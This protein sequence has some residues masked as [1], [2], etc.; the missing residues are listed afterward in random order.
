MS[1][2]VRLYSVEDVHHEEH[3]E[4]ERLS[5]VP[6][7]LKKAMGVTVGEELQAPTSIFTAAKGV[8][9]TKKPKR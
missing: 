3:H 2:T 9:H 8:V 4:E 7:H 5:L 1:T 6:P